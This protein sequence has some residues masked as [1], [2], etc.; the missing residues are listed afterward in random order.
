MKNISTALLLLLISFSAISSNQSISSFSTAKTKLETKVYFDHRVTLYCGADFNSKKYVTPPNGFTT[1]KYIK[2]S[3]KIEWEHVVP[4]ENFGRSFTEWEGDKACVNSK[5]KSFKGR[6]CAIK[7]N[8]E[9]R[10]MQADMFISI[11]CDWSC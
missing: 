5:G 11:S 2:R 10:F 3:K 4:A 9:Y 1:T 8:K 7:M 6:P